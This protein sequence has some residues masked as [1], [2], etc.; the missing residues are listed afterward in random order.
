MTV[1]V[2]GGGSSAGGKYPRPITRCNNFAAP[3]VMRS[4]G[5]HPRDN[6]PGRMPDDQMLSFVI[7][8]GRK[9]L[10]GAQTEN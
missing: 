2:G 4:D 9:S 5:G 10:F 7:R 8:L 1:G 3:L 6:S